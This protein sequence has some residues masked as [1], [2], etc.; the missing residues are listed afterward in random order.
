M[1]TLRLMAWFCAMP[2]TMLVAAIGCDGPRSPMGM[3]PQDY[4]VETS[5]IAGGPPESPQNER[6][7]S[8]RE[9]RFELVA[10][11]P[12][13][14]FSAD[15]NTASYSNIRNLLQNGQRPPVDAIRTAELINYFD[16]DYPR[17]KGDDPVAFQLEMGPCA[18]KPLHRVLK[19]SLAAK[20]FSAEQLPPRNLVFL[21]DTSG[22]MNAD[23]KIGLVKRSLKL[24]SESL[25]EQDWVSIVTYAGS[26]ELLLPTTSGAD[27]DSISRAIDSL[28]CNGS[29]NGAG[30]IV[31][32]Y[33]QA[34]KHPIAGG[35]N[36]VILMTDGD[37]NVGINNPTELQSL[38]EGKRKTGVYLTAIGFGRG[39]LRDDIMETLARHGNGHYGY[40]DSID[41]ARKLFA[42]QGGA[43]VTVAKDVK[44]QVEFNPLR[45][46]AY[47]LIGYE[48]RVMKAEDFKNDAKDAGDLGS[49]HT[50]TALFE[51][52]PTGVKLE[53]SGIDPL[54]YQATAKKA[55]DA[56]LTGEWCTVRMRYKQPDAETSAELT[57]KLGAAADQAK[58][59][60]DLRFASAVSMF[61]MLLRDSEFKGESNW[62]RV[63]TEAAAGQIA[64]RTGRRAEFL[65]LVDLAST[66]PPPS[67]V[68]LPKNARP[69]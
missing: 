32:A 48:N 17:P 21:V 7:E 23:N 42:D 67:S 49:G 66:L 14:T 16:Y 28:S 15:V 27:R 47:R 41:E 40:V 2:A 44:L 55:N 3:P 60:A 50:V 1:L 31:A 52:I 53:G 4:R 8:F 34:T 18:W 11:Q 62:D 59:S 13:A 51:I 30:G 25:R 35:I 29:T 26:S 69:E 61:A 22:S 36:R 20:R 58:P 37:F 12:L 68:P 9:N 64:D 45:V 39:N 43:L 54:K 5:Q 65:R 33:A 6:Y 38:I 46:A 63:R 56:A 24:L 10:Q 19:I 57:A